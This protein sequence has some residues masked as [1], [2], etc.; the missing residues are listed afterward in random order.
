MRTESTAEK[1]DFEGQV[2]AVTGGARGIGRGVCE[3]FAALG[4]DVAVVDIDEGKAAETASEIG[5][6]Y[7]VEAAAVECNVKEYEQAEAMVET[8]LEELGRLDVLVNNAGGGLTEPFAET[9]PADWDHVIDLCYYGT[10]NCS[11][12]ALPHM[13]DRG[14]GAIINFA[15]DSY[16]GNDPGLS[17]YGGV[18]AANVSATSTIAKEVGEHGVRVNCVSPGTTRTPATEDWLDEYGDSVVD[19]YALDR[20][21]EPEDIAD[22]VVFLASDAAD[23]ITGQVLS[24]NGGYI[25]G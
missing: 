11:H 8:V 1:I 17:I 15:S 16:K 3:A 18:K 13:T 6:E 19:A 2:A 20:L 23:W 24:V 22:A 4:G 10:L 25:R 14:S 9:D 5:T 7:G 21:G 12:A